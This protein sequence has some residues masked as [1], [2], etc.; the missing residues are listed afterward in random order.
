MFKELTL[1]M[2]TSRFIILSLCWAGVKEEELCL[3]KSPGGRR[4]G[5]RVW[6]DL[7]V[8]INYIGKIKLSSFKLGLG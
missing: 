5:G 4:Q 8:M 6:V 3:G 2:V 1:S 7:W